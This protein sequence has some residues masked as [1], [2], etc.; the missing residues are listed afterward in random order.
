MATDVVNT[1][2]G[3][4]AGIGALVGFICAGPMG[5][6]IGALVGGGVAHASG[7]SKG[8]M[9]PKREVIYKRALDGIKDPA[10]LRK[11]ADAFAG[12]GLTAQAAMLEKRAKLR[13]LPQATKEQ[14]RIAFR[15]AMASDNPDIIANIA[16]AFQSEGQF[17]AA[18][19]LSDHATAV[20]AAHMA[21]KSAKPMTGGTQEQFADKLGKAIIH[22]GPESNQAKGAAGNLI[23]ARGKT[24]TPALIAEVIKIAHQA[25]EI[26]TPT[27][28]TPKAPVQI[29]GREPDGPAPEAEEEST[30]A[31]GPA[32]GA[33]Q[34]AIE[35]TVVGPPAPTQMEPVVAGEATEAAAQTEE[36]VPGDPNA[37]EPAAS[38]TEEVVE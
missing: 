16:N 23:Q 38:P 15:K 31:T 27:A 11:L 25:L 32:I 14:R 22:F 26:R 24:P 21:G 5:A 36:V 8:L 19:A 7:Q 28:R 18:R 29:D 3:V 35:P 34:T 6:G 2:T 12:E 33:E 10:E 13:A 9:T 1:R 20:R 4:G 30:A 17:D 37:A